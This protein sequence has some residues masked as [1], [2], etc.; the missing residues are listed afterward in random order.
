MS[1]NLNRMLLVV[2]IL[3][4][5]G[6]S[7][8]GQ[9]PPAGPPPPRPQVDPGPALLL[10]PPPPPVPSRQAPRS[11][12]RASIASATI[13]LLPPPAGSPRPDAP[14]PR[15]ERIALA[16]PAPLT[17]AP[18]RAVRV[19]NFGN[20]VKTNGAEVAAPLGAT[21]RCRDGTYVSGDASD[22][23]CGGRGGL[24]IHMPG[25]RKPAPAPKR[26]S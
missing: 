26:G 8:A 25:Q 13:P 12:Q 20:V 18:P 1:Q 3:G 9:A 15:T 5:A 22:A 17:Q 24:A 16:N 4:G 19:R 7:A 6:R 2:S 23:S 21:G 10:P 14:P 11:E